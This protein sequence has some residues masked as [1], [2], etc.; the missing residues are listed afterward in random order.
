LNAF[1]HIGGRLASM[2]IS[3]KPPV[4]PTESMVAFIKSTRRRPRG[5][6]IPLIS[7]PKK[8]RKSISPHS[9]R[10]LCLCDSVVV[11]IGP[12]FPTSISP[13]SS[14]TI[15]GQSLT[16]FPSWSFVPSNLRVYVYPPPCISTPKI[17]RLPN[18]FQTSTYHLIKTAFPPQKSKGCQQPCAYARKFGSLRLFTPVNAVSPEQ[19]CQQEPRGFRRG[20]KRLPH[21]PDSRLPIY[22]PPTRPT[23]RNPLTL[24]PL[25]AYFRFA[26]DFRCTLRCAPA[27]V[28]AVGFLIEPFGTR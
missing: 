17:Q 14:A 23:R 21:P 27:T 16:V 5:R 7:T 1:W 10:P 3:V 13:R 15:C 9:V 18:Q 26:C 19:H 12:S 24:Q 4:T 11:L 8:N 25:N 2:R 20:D 28:L 22:D 6:R